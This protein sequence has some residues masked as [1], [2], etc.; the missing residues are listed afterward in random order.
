MHGC[1]STMGPTKLHV[2]R[3]V[4]ILRWSRHK[5]V[6]CWQRLEGLSV[7]SARGVLQALHYCSTAY[8]VRRT[9]VPVH[10]Y[11]YY[12]AQH[13]SQA[14]PGR[15]KCP[16]DLHARRRPKQEAEGHARRE[17]AAAGHGDHGTILAGAAISPPGPQRI[18]AQ[19]HY[20]CGIQI[21]RSQHYVV[22]PYR[23]L[24]LQYEYL[25]E[26]PLVAGLVNL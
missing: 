25:K 10:I 15:A 12:A 14:P 8:R 1:K 19:I 22:R 13:V 24:V 18:I 7:V 6:N 9:V 2:L 3:A 17:P 23:Q 21:D 5:W 16:A 26:F 20:A 4:W 11:Y